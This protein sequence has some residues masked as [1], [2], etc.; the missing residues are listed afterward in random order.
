[1]SKGKVQPVSS[2]NKK[3]PNVVQV[4]P[5]IKKRKTSKTSAEK[6]KLEADWLALIAKHATP[7]ERGAVSKGSKLETVPKKKRHSKHIE[8]VSGVPKLTVPPGRETPK[9]P[10]RVTG[11]HST[12]AKD[13]P[14]YTGTAMKGIGQMHKSNM[15]PLF[16]DEHMVDIATMRRNEYQRDPKK[17]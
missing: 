9:I 17:K 4:V 8:Q 10:S 11:G 6:R 15:I 16:S 7:L 13:V 2:K 3:K 12:K 1:M 14:T 5:S